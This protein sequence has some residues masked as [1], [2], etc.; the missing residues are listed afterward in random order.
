MVGGRLGLDHH[1]LRRLALECPTVDL[2]EAWERADEAAVAGQLEVLE[3]EGLAPFVEAGAAEGERSIKVSSE[4]DFKISKTI[5]KSNSNVFTDPKDEWIFI[6]LI[7]TRISE[8]CCGRVDCLG[9]IS[10]VQIESGGRVVPDP[11]ARLK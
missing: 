2:E 3:P 1:G 5:S 7:L 10:H 9:P 8:P 6:M 11:S 4:A